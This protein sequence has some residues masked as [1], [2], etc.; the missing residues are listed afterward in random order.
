LKG[1]DKMEYGLKINTRDLEKL[2]SAGIEY[3]PYDA[4]IFFM[5][6]EMPKTLEIIFEYKADLEKAKELLS[7]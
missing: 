7:K 2:D 5:G 3:M 6:K 4:E 1:F